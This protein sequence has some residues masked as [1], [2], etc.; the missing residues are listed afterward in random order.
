MLTT[1]R[2]VALGSARLGSAQLGSARYRGPVA[3]G[4]E[5]TAWG[6]AQGSLR[7]A[8]RAPSGSRQGRLAELVDVLAGAS[9]AEAAQQGRRSMAQGWGA[10]TGAAAVR[11]AGVPRSRERPVASACRGPQAVCEG[12]EGPVQAAGGTS[13]DGISVGLRAEPSAGQVAPANSPDLILVMGGCG[14]LACT[15][16]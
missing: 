4:R 14:C 7:G 9:S 10:A 5:H 2:S 12:N 1:M 13:A 15:L 3:E 8:S 11:G 16:H 6:S